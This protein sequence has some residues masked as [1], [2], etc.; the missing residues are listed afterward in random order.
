MSIDL[1]ASSEVNRQIEAGSVTPDS[2]AENAESM[3][4]C[5]TSGGE[6]HGN[7]FGITV[8]WNAADMV[9]CFPMMRQV[10]LKTILIVLLLALATACTILPQPTIIVVTPTPAGNVPTVVPTLETTDS[11]MTGRPP[12]TL[13]AIVGDNYT[14]E[15]TDTPR[16]TAGP[17]TETV[18]PRPST[19]TPGP[20]W[21]PVTPQPTSSPTP[22]PN[23][24]P[25]TAIPTQVPA[26]DSSRMGIQLLGNAGRA[27]WDASLTRAK[28]LGVG[29]I[30]VQVNWAF[31]QPDGY[32]PNNSRFND[33]HIN[34]E[35]ADQFGFKVMLSIA[36]APQ[37]TRA[38]HNGD[39]PPDN[40]QALGDFISLILST[41]MGPIV[42]AIEIWNEPNLRHDWGTDAY[43][44]TGEGYMRLF[45]PAYGAIRGNRSD[46]VIITAGLAPTANT[47]GTRNDREYL[48]EMYAAGLGNYRDIV[49]GAH[50]YG[51]ANPPD[52]RCCD[53]SAER[54]WDDQP[55]FFF[56]NNL[57]DMRE[58]MNRNG[59]SDI[60]LWVT[61]FGWAVWED[62]GIPLP[63]PAENNLWML[64]NS[65]IEQ[66]NYAIRAFEIGLSR[67]DIGV[68]VL[69][70]LN[71]ANPFTL[72]NRQEIAAYSILIMADDQTQ[73]TMA[74]PLFYLLPFAT[75]GG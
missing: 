6:T 73:Y 8:V 57:D 48:R 30:K 27:E 32:D 55:Q 21:T 26:L 39:G 65:P 61:E 3:F 58:T 43:P 34:I 54:G 25:P 10:S 7:Q 11:G 56:L 23:A 64:E 66:A 33:F 24:G 5:N 14:L 4:Y 72:A 49:I 53:S 69:W 36:K 40:P 19:F 59:H 45:G 52:A 29:W 37:W 18:P 12:V 47:E 75:R 41:K 71:Q 28:E 9:D 68:M 42:D 46:I 22:D 31:L 67:P 16:Y 70:N 60:Q 13:G 2:R 62:F 17:P 15:P 1:H 44:F 38:N 50:P 63:D 51:W 74:R 35:T 20:S